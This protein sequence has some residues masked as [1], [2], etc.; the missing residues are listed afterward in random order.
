[1]KIEPLLLKQREMAGHFGVSGNAFRAWGLPSVRKRGRE[2]LYDAGVCMYAR[3]GQKIVEQSQ[4]TATTLQELALGFVSARAV[5]GVIGGGEVRSFAMV[6]SRA[7]YERDMAMLALGRAAQIL[8]TK[9]KP[10][11][12][13]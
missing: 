8:G 7:G 6:A 4:G 9:T 10:E 13:A 12:R 5:E 2:R 1:M 3:L 11:R